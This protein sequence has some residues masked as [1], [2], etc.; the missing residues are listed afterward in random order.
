M[1]LISQLTAS[2][3]PVVCPEIKHVSMRLCSY[4]PTACEMAEKVVAVLSTLGM[5]QVGFVHYAHTRKGGCR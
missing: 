4:I 3:L 5:G 2:G 1:Q